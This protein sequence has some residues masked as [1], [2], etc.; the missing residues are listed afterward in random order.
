MKGYADELAVAGS[1]DVVRCTSG[2]P[3]EEA[4]G[5]PADTT[6]STEPFSSCGDLIVL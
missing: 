5:D 1:T 4:C 2:A 6:T 3:M